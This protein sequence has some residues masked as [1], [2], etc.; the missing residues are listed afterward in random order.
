MDHRA[1]GLTVTNETNGKQQVNFG[2][3][4]GKKVSTLYTASPARPLFWIEM[5]P[6]SRTQIMFI[7]TGTWGRIQISDSGHLLIHYK[8]K[9]L[10]II[11]RKIY[12]KS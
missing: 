8:L 1:H 4:S 9:V 5:N 12:M 3:V 6:F 2:N 11:L 7:G 10:F